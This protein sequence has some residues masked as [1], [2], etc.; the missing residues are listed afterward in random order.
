[1]ILKHLAFADDVALVCLTTEVMTRL[2]A[3]LEHGLGLVGLKAKAA[4]SAS[5]GVRALGKQKTWAVSPNPYLTQ[6]GSSAQ[7]LT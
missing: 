5:L 1:M 6:D 3:E 2:L 4:K 7:R